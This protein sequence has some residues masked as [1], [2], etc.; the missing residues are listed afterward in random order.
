M[1]CIFGFV[2]LTTGVIVLIVG[3]NASHSAAGQ[4]SRTLT[5][6]FIP[7]TVRYVFGGGA[8]VLVGLLLIPS[9]SPRQKRP[10]LLAPRAASGVANACMENAESTA[11]KSTGQSG[12]RICNCLAP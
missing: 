4:I 7:E 2:L 1:Q 8:A 6:R 12:W 3:I 11:I 9:G 5:E 10:T